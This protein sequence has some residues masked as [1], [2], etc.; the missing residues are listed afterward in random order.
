[1][2]KF[3]CPSLVLSV[4]PIDLLRQSYHIFNV[5]YCPTFRD[6]QTY[7]SDIILLPNLWD[8]NRHVDL[9]RQL[10]TILHF[11]TIH[12]NIQ[13]HY[14]LLQ[15]RKNCKLKQLHYILLQNR[16]NCRL[17]QFHYIHLLNRNNCKLKQFHYIHLL[18]RNN[19][20]LKYSFTTFTC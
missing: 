17:K 14:I 9:L 4:K 19:C 1:M 6:I 2:T 8:I 18:N 16:N 13:F 15:N 10:Y 11:Y 3:S 12:L 20:K 5:T 7:V